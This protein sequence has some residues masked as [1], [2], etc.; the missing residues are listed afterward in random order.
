MYSAI[1]R[2]YNSTS[3]IVQFNR[4]AIFRDVFIICARATWM[5]IDGGK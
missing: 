3:G 1:V 2:C 4:F 5:S